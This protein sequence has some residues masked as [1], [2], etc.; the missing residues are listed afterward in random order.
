MVSRFAVIGAVRSASSFPAQ[1]PLWTM[2]ISATNAAEAAGRGS[3][4]M[5]GRLS[6]PP[7]VAIVRSRYHRAHVLDENF[8][9]REFRGRHPPE[10]GAARRTRTRGNVGP[11][12]C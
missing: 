12:T 10:Q 1:M 11:T 9:R 2:A 8:P 3:I 7:T 4:F 6:E 5:R